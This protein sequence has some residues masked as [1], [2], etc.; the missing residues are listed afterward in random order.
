MEKNVAYIILVNFIKFFSSNS[1]SSFSLS[2]L[3]GIKLHSEFFLI[4]HPN[5]HCF[6]LLYHGYL[7]VQVA[8]IYLSLLSTRKTTRK[9]RRK[10]RR[11]TTTRKTKTKRKKK[12]E[13]GR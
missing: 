3:L 4:F 5:E 12:V 10:T 9:K 6:L 13:K 1:S 8:L 11:K 2:L 7:L